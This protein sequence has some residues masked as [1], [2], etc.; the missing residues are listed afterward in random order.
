MLGNEAIDCS[1]GS[2]KSR[3]ARKAAVQYP[4]RPVRPPMACPAAD[5]G[6]AV[7]GIVPS[8]QAMK[9]RPL[10]DSSDRPICP[11]SHTFTFSH[12]FMNMS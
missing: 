11:S 8:R 12:P 7:S 4:I 9:L 1:V 5:S 3:S 6:A 10:R 2:M